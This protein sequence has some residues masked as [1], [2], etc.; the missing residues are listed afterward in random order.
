M[1]KVFDI[2]E[3]SAIC[4]GGTMPVSPDYGMIISNCENTIVKDNAMHNGSLIN[5]LIEENNK[6]CV[7]ENN[8]GCLFSEG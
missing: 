7:I 6:N 3:F 2:T 5:N 8:I 4:D 1:K